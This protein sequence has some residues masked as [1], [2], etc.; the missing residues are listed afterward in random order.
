MSERSR[1]LIVDDEKNLLEVLTLLFTGQGYEVTAASSL[2]RARDA[3]EHKDFDLVLCDIMMPEGSGLDLLREIREADEASSVIMITAST[4][5]G[6]AVEA[7]KLGAYDYVSKPFDVEE[8]KILVEKALEK[9]ELVGENLYLRQELENRYT[10]SNMIGKSSRMQ[11]VFSLIERVS[12]TDSTVL[13]NGESGTGKELIARAIHFSGRRSKSRFVSINCGAM[14]ESLLESELFGH[15]RGAFTGAVKTKIGLFQ[16]ASNGTLFLDEISEM[17]PPMQVKLLRVL[18]EKE[19]RKVGGTTDERINTRIVAATNKDLPGMIEQGG[20]REDLYYR[21]NVI[22]I[23]LPPLRERREDIPLLVEHFIEKCAVQMGMMPKRVTAQAMDRLESYQWPG[24]VRE[25]ENLVERAMALSTHEHIEASDLPTQ[26]R[27]GIDRV[28]ATIG[29]P[30]DGLDLEQHLDSIRRELMV[31]AL[32]RT[33]WVQT[34]AAELVGMTFRSFRYYAKKAGLTS[35]RNGGDVD[36]P[37][38]EVSVPE[39]DSAFVS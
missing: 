23:G 2:T 35:G 7:M 27:T 25:L 31:Q 14:P 5:T 6:T 4:S 12:R 29:L 37:A 10:F 11:Q 21:I 20:F 13:I 18:Q 16:E 17:P 26:V 38:D 9:A 3:L 39:H 24:N 36:T 19:V 33:N 34:Q 8:L 15:E 28:A 22:P 30:K 1:L 32:D